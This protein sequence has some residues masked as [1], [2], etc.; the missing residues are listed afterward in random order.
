MM[1]TR[2]QLKASLEDIKTKITQLDEERM[3]IDTQIKAL[4]RDK[5]VIE[6]RLRT[7]DSPSTTTPLTPKQILEKRR[8]LRA[9]WLYFTTQDLAKRHQHKPLMKHIRRIRGRVGELDRPDAW[10]EMEELL[11]LL[12]DELPQL[13][14]MTDLEFTRL[15]KIIFSE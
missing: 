6:K 13:R 9:E 10:D 8:R 2:E 7:S 1:R 3:G 15:Q 14:E 5:G 4:L 12:L 11:D